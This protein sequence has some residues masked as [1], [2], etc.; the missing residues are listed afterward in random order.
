[1]SPFLARRQYNTPI[2]YIG[3][4]RIACTDIE[5]APKRPRKNDLSLRG[6][7]GLHGKT[8]LPS[9]RRFRNTSSS[10]FYRKFCAAHGGCR[11]LKRTA[12]AEEIQTSTDAA[13]LFRAV[14]AQSYLL[15][16]AAYSA[17]VFP[18][19]VLFIGAKMEPNKVVQICLPRFA[20][21]RPA[22]SCP[23]RVPKKRKAQK[24]FDERRTVNAKVSKETT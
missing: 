9:W 8:I 22:A 19:F 7:C 12:V 20:S 18:V 2:L 17:D 24:Q 1:M 4:Q 10:C 13:S 21:N 23:V 14:V 5:A 16:S 15:D 6:D 11:A 3:V